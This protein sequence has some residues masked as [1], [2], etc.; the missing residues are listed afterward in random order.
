MQPSCQHQKTRFS[1][2]AD[3]VFGEPEDIQKR[4]YT[5][6]NRIKTGFPT[7]L[8]DPLARHIQSSESSVRMD[9][10]HTEK[11]SLYPFYACIVKIVGSR[12]WA[13]NG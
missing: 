9:K 10:K 4:R 13:V 6:K 5:L 12:Q 7:D 1:V 11:R 8:P 2:V 3:D